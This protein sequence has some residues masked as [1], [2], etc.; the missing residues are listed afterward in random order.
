MSD[1]S[2]LDGSCL[3]DASFNTLG[4]CDALVGIMDSNVL[5]REDLG[6]DPIAHE[7]SERVATTGA[8]T[9]NQIRVLLSLH[10]VGQ[11]D[12]TCLMA[13]LQHFNRFIGVN[14][15]RVDQILV[16]HFLCFF[17]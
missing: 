10:S 5:G 8:A 14:S 13:L 15:F 17:I 2:F 3:K 4:T 11:V 16:E 12:Q 9:T 1:A 6:V 7:T